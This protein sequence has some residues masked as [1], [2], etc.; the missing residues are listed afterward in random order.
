MPWALVIEFLEEVSNITSNVYVSH[1]K[2]ITPAP[3]GWWWCKSMMLLIAIMLVV[4]LRN[5]VG[6]A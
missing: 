3:A 5:V 6:I 4:G 2:N 1:H